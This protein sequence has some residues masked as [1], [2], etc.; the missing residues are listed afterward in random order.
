MR[1]LIALILMVLLLTT[2]LAY[3]QTY[4]AYDVRYVENVPGKLIGGTRAT[5][6][7]GIKVNDSGHPAAGSGWDLTGWRYVMLDIDTGTHTGWD[8]TP[9][10]GDGDQYYEGTAR[11]ISGDGDV[12]YIVNVNGNQDFYVMIDGQQTYS[13]FNI[14]LLTVDVQPFN[15]I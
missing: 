7:D 9:L 6:R 1:K 10:F 15:Q 5:M 2:G 4:Y 11:T 8:I 14:E 3:A 13:P 12:Q